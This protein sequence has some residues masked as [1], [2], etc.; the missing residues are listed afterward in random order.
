MSHSAKHVFVSAAVIGLLALIATPAEAALTSI[1]W[2]KNL[3]VTQTNAAGNTTLDGYFFFARG[4][5]QNAGDFTSGELL[6]P[7]PN[8]PD[9]FVNVP[10]GNF[11]LDQTGFFSS[12]A[13]L[14][15]AYPTGTYT[16]HFMNSGD[17]FAALNYFSDNYPLNQPI[18]T[19]PTFTG[20]Q[21]MDSTQGFTISFSPFLTNPG[22][23]A[24]VIDVRI[25]RSFDGATVFADNGLASST[26]SVFLPAGT[27]DPGT[28]YF[29]QTIFESAVNQTDPFNG[30]P[31]TLRWDNRTDAF[32][33]TGVSAAVPE[34][35]TVT[36]LG[37]G[38]AL[39]G[40]LKSRR[41][42]G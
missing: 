24:S 40:V 35:G 5:Y 37:L 8:S 34:P 30:I 3:E 12:Q 1:D 11:F 9:T 15:T 21:G 18:Y 27:L 4:F 33:T 29:V 2:G 22:A 6:Y 31:A 14:D 7:G 38:V 32:F 41:L 10:S 13:A 36:L 42:R 26:T 23:D 17:V 19:A 25:T 20:L 16:Y 28:T 39:A